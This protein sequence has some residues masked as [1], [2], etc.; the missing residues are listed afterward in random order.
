MAPAGQSGGL[1]EADMV[2]RRCANTGVSAFPR[3]RL[4]QP[5]AW[6]TKAEKLASRPVS[7]WHIRILTDWPTDVLVGTCGHEVQPR[8]RGQRGDIGTADLRRVEG[9]CPDGA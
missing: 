5:Y 4:L 3:R 7:S 9:R 1:T 8:L 6:A 2:R